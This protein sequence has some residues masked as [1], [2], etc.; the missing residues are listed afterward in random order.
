MFSKIDI[1]IDE[2]EEMLTKNF[3]DKEE[4]GEKYS[5]IMDVQSQRAKC[6]Q[7]YDKIKRELK[8]LRK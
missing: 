1:L 5:M 7:K 3:E 4:A 6:K 8:D 2:K